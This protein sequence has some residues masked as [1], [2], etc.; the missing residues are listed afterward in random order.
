MRW[1]DPQTERLD[2]SQSGYRCVR[3]ERGV[4]IAVVVGWLAM[5][6]AGSILLAASQK[7]SRNE[8]AAQA[9]SKAMSV[10]AFVSIYAHDLLTREQAQAQAFLGTDQ[11]STSTLTRAA[12]A[13]GLRAALLLDQRAEVIGVLRPA[14]G[15]LDAALLTRYLGAT[16]GGAG[17][18][19]IALIEFGG[20]GMVSF[21]VAFHAGN[22]SR[23]LLGAYPI[24]D[25]ALPTMMGRL[26]STPR[27]RVYLFDPTGGLLVGDPT[28]GDGP[29]SLPRSGPSTRALEK[30]A[31]PAVYNSARPAA[32]STPPDARAKLRYF[33]ANVSGT[34]W[35][36]M[37]SNR[38][39]QL[40][41]FMSLAWA[42]LWGLAIA[43]LAIIIVIA[44][45]VRGRR[46]LGELNIELARLA[47]TDPLTEL[48]NRR[49]IK[50][51]LHDA[52]SAARRHDLSLSILLVDV[53]R[54][55]NFNDTLGHRTGDA[56]LAHAARVLSSSLRAEDTVGRWGGDEFLVVLPG[57]DES[58]ALR[59]TE[60]LRAALADDQPEEAGLLGRRVTVTIGLAEWRREDME[61]FIGRADVA[62]YRGKEA[63]RDTV[64][65]A[66]DG[67]GSPKMSGGDSGGSAPALGGPPPHPLI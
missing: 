20:E 32:T 60:R 34:P 44:R 27:W 35:R 28:A 63:G 39:D 2:A 65:A 19:R 24:S 16:V 29:S 22:E 12:S 36:I 3:R 61:E 55:K 15:S 38:E 1:P 64:R 37:V 11:V 66:P 4:L 5:I 21:A 40:H 8:L 67:G 17:G 42:A 62:L 46:Q 14:P 30:R 53:D 57:T 6:A 43:G 54:F 13:M 50:E 47:A 7:A 45:L 18:P 26:V 23:V 59:V 9:Q 48:K 52:L 56:V 10:A 51:Y 58:G 31:G 49:A 33:A 25:T 41:G